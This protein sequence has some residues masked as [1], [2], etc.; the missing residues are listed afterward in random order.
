[1]LCYCSLRFEQISIPDRMSGRSPPSTKWNRTCHKRKH[2]LYTCHVCCPFCVNFL[3]GF[4]FWPLPTVQ[5]IDR[6]LPNFTGPCSMDMSNQVPEEAAVVSCL[7]C[8]R[9]LS[10]HTAWFLKSDKMA[11]ILRP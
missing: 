10:R 2:M 11:E 1:M 8:R 9:G 7:D 6:R 3:Q 5:H 4:E